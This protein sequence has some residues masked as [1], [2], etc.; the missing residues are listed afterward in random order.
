[1]N[2]RERTVKKLKANQ[3]KLFFTEGKPKSAKQKIKKL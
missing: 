3:G 1:M 2:R